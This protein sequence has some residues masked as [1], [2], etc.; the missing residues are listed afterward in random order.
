[1]NRIKEILAQKD[2][3]VVGLAT[4]LGKSP[5]ALHRQIQGKMLVETAEEIANALG[6]ELWELFASPNIVSNPAT[7]SD[8]C[9]SKSLRCP[10]CGA[11]LS[12]CL[13]SNDKTK[14]P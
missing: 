9:T 11:E 8:T 14:Q 13:S 4:K 12:V 3:T 1:M 6:V 5:Q 2:M 10:V 7:H